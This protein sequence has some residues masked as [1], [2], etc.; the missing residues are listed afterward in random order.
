M[1]EKLEKTKSFPLEF[2]HTS[3][4]QTQEVLKV[5]Y[6]LIYSVRLGILKLKNT[7]CNYSLETVKSSESMEDLILGTI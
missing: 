3:I 5:T 7:F 2:R 4:I 1:A 6:S